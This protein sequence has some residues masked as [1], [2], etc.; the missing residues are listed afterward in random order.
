MR[1]H[2]KI[3]K[4]Y[5]YVAEKLAAK[6]YFKHNYVYLFSKNVYRYV[7]VC[8]YTCETE[9]LSAPS[10]PFAQP[11]PHSKC[12]RGLLVQIH[13]RVLYEKWSVAQERFASHIGTLLWWTEGHH[14]PLSGKDEDRNRS[15]R[16]GLRV[17]SRWST[18][19]E[20]QKRSILTEGRGHNGWG[21]LTHWAERPESEQQGN[22]LHQPLYL[23]VRDQLTAVLWFFRE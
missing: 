8:V 11:H 3:S 7:C 4:T 5:Y 21:L 23:K 20:E 22:I 12:E 19:T 10:T 13:I 17:G 6:Q 14:P 18:L 2:T 16:F 15:L 1:T 9:K